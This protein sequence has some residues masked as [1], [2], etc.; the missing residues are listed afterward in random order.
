[1]PRR[2]PLL[3]TFLRRRARHRRQHCA[4]FRAKDATESRRHGAADAAAIGHS[5]S[6]FS[7]S[8]RA[9]LLSAFPS[10]CDMLTLSPRRAAIACLRHDLP[11]ASDMLL[12]VDADIFIAR[13]PIIAA[14]IISFSL[15]DAAL[16]APISREPFSITFAIFAAAASAGFLRF[17]P[18]RAFATG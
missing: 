9:L 17:S 12:R 16:P 15:A 8:A 6:L 1:M 10:S 13:L 3:F 14:A 18:L 7:I 11:S 5:F 4:L 2:W